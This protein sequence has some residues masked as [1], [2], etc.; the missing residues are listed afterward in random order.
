M[1]YRIEIWIHHNLKEAFESDSVERC[2]EWIDE[3]WLLVSQEGN[4]FI[5]VMKY[6][7]QEW[8]DITFT[9]ERKKIITI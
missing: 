6:I 7:N 2:N 3:N 8:K 9:D 1:K 4:C 5:Q